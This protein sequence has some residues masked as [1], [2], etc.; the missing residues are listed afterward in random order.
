MHHA[1]CI[2]IMLDADDEMP[3]V[4]VHLVGL[5]LRL[6]IK[7]PQ[8]AGLAAL[9]EELWVEVE[10]AARRLVHQP[11]VGIA[12]AQMF[13]RHRQ[14]HRALQAR[15][16][17]QLFVNGVLEFAAHF[18]HPFRA[19]RLAVGCVHRREHGL[20][21]GAE[22]RE[23]ALVVLV[24]RINGDDFFPRGRGDDIGK[25]DAFQRRGFIEQPGDE[26]VDGVRL[27]IG[28]RG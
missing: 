10:N 21:H 8:R 27:V 28:R 5:A 14:R 20:E 17:V 15:H 3:R 25:A 13:A 26:L 12:G 4:V 9:R 7:G 18:V 2:A 24:L 23:H 11:Q 1:F 6:E 22:L 19:A 16:G